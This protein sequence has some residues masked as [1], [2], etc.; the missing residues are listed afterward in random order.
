MAVKNGL[1]KLFMLESLDHEEDR[2]TEG[3]VYTQKHKLVS[4]PLPPKIS[5]TPDPLPGSKPIVA[6]MHKQIK[7]GSPASAVRANQIYSMIKAAGW[8]EEDLKNVLKFTFNAKS[9]Y[10]TELYE[11]QYQQLTKLLKEG[12]TVAQARAAHVEVL[13]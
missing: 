5:V 6:D 1:L 8:S 11:S 13:P 4:K 12:K 10:V 7:V 3:A 2:P 9:G